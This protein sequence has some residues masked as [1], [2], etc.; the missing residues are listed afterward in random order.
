MID[1][2]MITVG[3]VFHCYHIPVECCILPQCRARALG[4][5]NYDNI[6]HPSLTLSS[7]PSSR[8]TIIQQFSPG[9]YSQWQC[10][11][12]THTQ[13]W[14]QAGVYELYTS[15][16]RLLSRQFSF[17]WKTDS[18]PQSINMSIISENLS[19]FSEQLNKETWNMNDWTGNQDIN[20]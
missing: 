14:P 3:R 19:E 13:A 15:M 9:S 4:C 7:W 8:A 12:G 11:M 2:I 20:V 5:I 18:K 10:I 17:Y 16:P 6:F 1:L